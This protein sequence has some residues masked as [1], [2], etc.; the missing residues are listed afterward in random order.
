MFGSAYNIPTPL[1]IR[2][3][4]HPVL[5]HT[6]RYDTRPFGPFAPYYA[7]R[8]SFWRGD[9]AWEIDFIHHRL[10]L[11]NTTSEIEQFEIHYGYSYLLA[12]RAWR[13]RG[14]E[15][16]ASGG[17]VITNP[18]NVVRGMPMNTLGAEARAGYD[19]TGVG[20]LVRSQPRFQA[21]R[22]FVAHR[23]RGGCRG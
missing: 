17:V 23:H 22:P 1:T 15:L 8:I 2:Q 21:D 6:A 4:D 3:Q 18:A 16:H 11:S 5:Q 13:V 7:G 9:A 14:V 12:G 20:A 10:F 19:I